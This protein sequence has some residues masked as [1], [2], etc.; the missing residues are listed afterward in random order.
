MSMKSKQNIRQGLY[1]SD[2]HNEGMLQLDLV[3]YLTLHV[4][5]VVAHLRQAREKLKGCL[6]LRLQKVIGVSMS[7]MV[8][9]LGLSTPSSHM[10]TVNDPILRDSLCRALLLPFPISL[11]L[12]PSSNSPIRQLGRA[13][14]YRLLMAQIKVC[15]SYYQKA[16]TP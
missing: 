13:E 4:V 16:A 12:P 8:N 1:L 11:F 10:H 6:H 15:L 5:F 2:L 9:W 14:G 3:L 7:P